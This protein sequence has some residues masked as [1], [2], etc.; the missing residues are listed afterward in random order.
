VLDRLTADTFAPAVGDTFAV[1]AGDA[2][3]LRLELIESRLQYPDRPAEDESGTR[4]PFSLLFRGP[5]D[6]VLPQRIYRLEHESLGPLEI[7][8]VPIARDDAGS[9]YEAVFA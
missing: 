6:P 7:F 8:I 9:T 1:D 5:A 4:A 3:E 2:G